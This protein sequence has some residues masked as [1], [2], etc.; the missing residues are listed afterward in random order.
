M[1]RHLYNNFDAYTAICIS[2][3]SYNICQLANLHKI[4]NKY[5]IPKMH[6]GETGDSCTTFYKSA[7]CSQYMTDRIVYLRGFERH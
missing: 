2:Y 6:L 7:I 4:S 5:S 3:S 1:H